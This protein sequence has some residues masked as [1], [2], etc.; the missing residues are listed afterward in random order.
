[1]SKFCFFGLKFVKKLVFSSQICQ[2]SDFKVK[3]LVLRSKFC[4]F[5]VKMYQNFGFSGKNLSKVWFLGSNLS[6]FWF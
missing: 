5:K 3:I 4:I 6:K 2:N 1:M